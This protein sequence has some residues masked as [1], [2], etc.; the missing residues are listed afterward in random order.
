[1]PTGATFWT[2]R[3]REVAQNPQRSGTVEGA[4]GDRHLRILVHRQGGH[5]SGAHPITSL[6]AGSNPYRL[7]QHRRPQ[8]RARSPKS[9]RPVVADHR[10]LVEKENSRP[11]LSRHAG[12]HARLN[13]LPSHVAFCDTY[14]CNYFFYN[15]L[16][17]TQALDRSPPRWDPCILHHT[18]HL[19]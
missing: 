16:T 13:N 15:K 17:I 7:Q 6:P 3:C 19:L 14:E 1:M 11:L 4:S 18:C 9:A 8:N 10:G 2:G 12:H 5:D